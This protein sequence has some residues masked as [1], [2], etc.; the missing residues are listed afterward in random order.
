MS[1]AGRFMGRAAKLAQ[2]IGGQR[3]HSRQGAISRFCRE[4]ANA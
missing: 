2:P 3:P 4:D 1:L